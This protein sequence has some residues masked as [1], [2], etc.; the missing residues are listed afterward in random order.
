MTKTLIIA[1]I[2][3]NHNADL[4]LAYQMIDAAV[5]A[6]ADA[7]KF[8]TAIPELV[9]TGYAT[10]AGYQKATTDAGESQLAMIKRL[11][12]PLETNVELKR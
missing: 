2:G 12:F 7:V 3:V 6:G 9:A 11:L 4:K 10:K 8:Q 1:E 5:A